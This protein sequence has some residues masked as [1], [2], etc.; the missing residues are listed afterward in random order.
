[1]TGIITVTGNKTLGSGDD[2]TLQQVTSAAIITIPNDATYDFVIGDYIH[3]FRDTAS[4]VSIAAGGGV[5]LKS[6][7][8]NLSSQNTYACLRKIAANTWIAWGSL[9]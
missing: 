3:L 2:G 6:I 8:T 7:G 1:M 5:T 9:S 4:A